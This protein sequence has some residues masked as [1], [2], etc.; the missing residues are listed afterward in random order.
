MRLYHGTRMCTLEAKMILVDFP[1]VGKTPNGLGFYVTDNKRIA[2]QY[3][4]VVEWEVSQ[5]WTCSLMRP[6]EV[7]GH[8]GIEYVLSQHEANDMATNAL[9]TTIN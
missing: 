7:Y 9:S 6:I 8:A 5:E 4:S 1:L 2:E 3:G